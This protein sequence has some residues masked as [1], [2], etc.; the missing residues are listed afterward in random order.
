LSTKSAPDS[1]RAGGVPSAAAR[2]WAPYVVVVL[3]IWLAWQ[4]VV[5]LLVQRAPVETAVRVAPSSAQVLSRAA[6]SEL[7]AD[8]PDQA[9]VLAALALRAAPFDVRAL[10]VLGLVTARTDEDAADPLL[11]LA[12]N[13]SLRDDPSH[14]WLMN[15]R[16]RQGDYAGA[17]GHADVLARRRADLRP[18]VFRLFTAAA[19]ADPRAI[20]PL[21]ARVRPSPNWRLE[22]L[23]TLR[24]DPRG[25]PA[26]QAA[27]ALGLQ[28]GP[29][30]LTDLELEAIYLD[31]AEAGRLAGLAALRSRLR[32]PAPALL[33]DGEFSSPPAPRP[34]RWV[35]GEAPGLL[36]TF[37]EKPDDVEDQALFVE[38]D[39]FD[40][41]SVASQ[42]LFLPAGPHTVGGDF[43]FDAGGTSEILE[44]G[45][46]CVE[47]GAMLSAWRPVAAG[48]ASDWA[49]GGMAFTVPQQG[50]T[51]QWLTLISRPGE[52][53]TTIVAWFDRLTVAPSARAAEMPR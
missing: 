43:R 51:A 37:S 23:G 52:R 27:L 41:K 10:R 45:V 50:C 47:S 3:V 48:D 34:F 29:G 33:H 25:V 2:N 14:A 12:G 30:A 20:G 31:W 1:R 49:R 28:P 42:L 21:V 35:L 22:Y 15:R 44:W 39:G 38:T 40:L 8:R 46:R 18:G 5:A 17:F 36:A 26:V 7:V 4:I 19:T 11:T 9:R 24:A 16:L 53:R 13:W 32:R 6:E